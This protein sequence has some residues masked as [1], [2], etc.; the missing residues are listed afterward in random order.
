LKLPGRHNVANALAAIAVGRELS[1]PFETIAR[2]IEA[3]TGV[4]R[5]FERKGERAG[6]LVVDDYAHHPTEIAATLEAA[7]Q[8]YP[9]RRLVALFQPHLFS[10][11][12]DFSEAFGR[13]LSAADAS[14]VTDVYPSREK[15]IPGVTGALV[16]DAARRAGTSKCISY[17]ADRKAVVDYL[18]R[19]LVPGDLLVTLGAGDVVKF[20]E[21]Y[22]K[23]GA[24]R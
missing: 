23:R 19:V 1:I 18:E 24:G 14:V 6:V 22:L 12:R 3:F 10:R 13:A 4:V 21:E 2:A 16:A 17:V 7:R 15:P 8:V 9:D 5:R 20:G 11:T